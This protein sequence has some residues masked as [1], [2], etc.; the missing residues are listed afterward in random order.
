MK[1]QRSANNAVVLLLLWM[2]M[3]SPALSQSSG[4]LVTPTR[5][6]SKYTELEGK[7]AQAVRAKDKS[8][9]S[10]MLDDEFELWMAPQTEAVSREDWTIGWNS[11]SL[12]QF[13]PHDM[14]VRTFG[15]VEVAS[16]LAEQKGTFNGKNVSG[17]YFIVDV[18]KQVGDEWKLA[19]R[20]QS[21]AGSAAAA[22]R[23]PT[24]KE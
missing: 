2:V 24:G 22:H 21:K 1:L 7:L 6:V 4:R 11:G 15:T 9:V 5:T 20:Y 17:S 8:A 23:R 3:T 13:L 19:V 12:A 14:V 10:A 16:F 18:W